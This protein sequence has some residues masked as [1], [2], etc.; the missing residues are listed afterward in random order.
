MATLPPV[1]RFILD[2]FQG[3]TTIS[4]FAAKLFYPLN[5]FLTATYSALAN[6]LTLNANTIGMVTTQSSITSSSAGVATT[7]INWPYPQ[8]PPTGLAVLSCLVN[9]TPALSPLVSWSYNAGVVSVALQ[10]LAVG[11]ISSTAAI[12]PA[13]SQTYSLTFWVSGG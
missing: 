9:A 13:A 7:T 10:F 4:A 3:V 2:D 6:G 5:L 1:K 11:S 8:S 12:V